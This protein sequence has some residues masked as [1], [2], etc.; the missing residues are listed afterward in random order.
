[1]NQDLYVYNTLSRKK[2]KFIPL[3]P[4]F[5]GMYACG[6]TVYGEPHL[7]HARQAVTFDIIYRY[8]MQ[9]GYRVRYVRNITDVGHLEH[10]ADEGEDKIARRAR[11]EKLEPMEIVQRYTNEYRDKMKMLNI[12]P[13][14]I[15]PVASG[16]IIEQQDMVARILEKGFAYEVNGSVYFDVDKYHSKYGYGR[17][18]GRK[19]E[20]LLTSTRPLNKQD[21]KRNP[22]DFAIWK[23]AEPE[24]IMRWPSAWSE[25]FPGWHLE[26][27]VMSVKYLGDT[28]DIHGGGMDLLFP[29]HEC[30]IA[31]NV[32]VTGRESVRYWMHNNLITIN[33][34]KMSKSLNNSI[35]L[36]QCFTGTHELLERSYSPMTVRFFMLQAHYRST[37]DFSN[38]ALQAAEKGL[39]RLFD[40]MENLKKIKPSETSSFNPSD[41]EK[42]F[43]EAMNDDL[44]T[45]VAVSVL[46][47]GIKNI[48][49]TAAG[50]EKLTLQDI[51]KTFQMYKEIT[52][53]ILGLKKEAVPEGH[54]ELISGLVELLL[55]MRDEARDKK[56]FKTAD[57]IRTELSRLGVTVKDTRDGNE[58][59]IDSTR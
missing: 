3:H 48:N 19:I 38:E 8:L 59:S 21:E 22:L 32:A 43:Y 10:D 34:Q 33:G 23:R 40:G 29:H 24:H 12:L 18:S 47:E 31:Q 46:F 5:V 25:G 7:G 49:A 13:P 28:F 45:P 15:E 42:R 57:K 56:D 58:W 26:C 9:L 51:E 4:P 37:L 36:E 20:D 55:T 35:S 27:S 50:T 11:L 54:D 17:L 16:H 14:S 52:E 2:E 44:N 30:E 53:K 6:P 39:A 41:I 1:M